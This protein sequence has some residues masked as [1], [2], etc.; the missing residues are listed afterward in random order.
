MNVMLFRSLHKRVVGANDR[1][2][3]GAPPA[4]LIFRRSYPQE[5]RI[6]P[7]STVGHQNFSMYSTTSRVPSSWLT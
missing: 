4:A 2:T 5:A 1:I 7:L 3:A 6:S